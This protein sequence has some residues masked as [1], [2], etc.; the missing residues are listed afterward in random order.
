MILTAEQPL[1]R[2]ETI[3]AVHALEGVC[4]AWFSER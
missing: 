4:E 3:A 1:T 2:A